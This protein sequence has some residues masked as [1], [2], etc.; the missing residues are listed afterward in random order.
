[1]TVRIF[2]AD[3]MQASPGRPTRIWIDPSECDS[4]IIAAVLTFLYTLDYTANGP[5]LLKFG[6]PH[7]D[8][9]SNEVAKPAEQTLLDLAIED[10][11]S[12]I[13]TDDIESLGTTE[14]ETPNTSSNGSARAVRP[15]DPGEPPNELVFHTQTYLAG[16]RFG[17]ASLCAIA[18]EKFEKRLKSDHWNTEMISCIR[19]AYRHGN[20]PKLAEL[21][22]TIVKSARSRFRVLKTSQGWD[23]LVI[24]FPEFAAELLKRM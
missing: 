1:M 2:V 15:Q 5:P 20:N 17:I 4:H 19:E 12:I 24:D 14:V 7:E 3:R 9:D 21:K 16:Q 6:L 11:S 13:S 22:E 18:K 23:D 10:N 8:K